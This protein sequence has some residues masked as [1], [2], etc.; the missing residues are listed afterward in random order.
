MRRPRRRPPH[1]PLRRQHSLA[2]LAKTHGIS[3]EEAQALEDSH[4]PLGRSS[5]PEEIGRAAV[6]LASDMGSYITGVALPVAGGMAP[7]L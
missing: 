6:F 2:L 1:P 7:G 4:I 3:I 5:Q